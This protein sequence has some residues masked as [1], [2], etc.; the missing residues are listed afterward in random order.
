MRDRVATPA[1]ARCPSPCCCSWG[2]PGPAPPSRASARAAGRPGDLPLVTRPGA[3]HR[4]AVD[5]LP[6]RRPRRRLRLRASRPSCRR[7]GMLGAVAVGRGVGSRRAAGA[8][9]WRS[10]CSPCSPPRS[11]RPTTPTTRPTAGS[12]PGRRPLP[13]AAERLARRHDPVTSAVEPPW[14]DDAERLRAVRHAAAGA[15]LPR[16]RRQPARDRLGVAGPR[17][18]GLAGRAVPAAAG[19]RAAATP[20]RPALDAQPARLRRRG[21]RR[22]RRPRRAALALAALVLAAR[23]PLGR[24]ALAG[25]AVS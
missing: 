9:R 17:R 8:G 25:L 6:A 21:A 12:R 7:R 1:L 4:A 13:D 16:R 20:G 15:D 18:A 24:G 2:S 19:R 22:P 23:S 3:G 5:R 10:A 11:A 14:T